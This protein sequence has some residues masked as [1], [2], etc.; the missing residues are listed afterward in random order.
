[1]VCHCLPPGKQCRQP[2]WALLL[3]KPWHRAMAY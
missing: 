1:V 2:V 3:A